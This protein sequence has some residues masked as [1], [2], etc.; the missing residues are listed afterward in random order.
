MAKNKFQSGIEVKGK[1]LLSQESASKALTID[2]NGEITSSATTDTELGHLSGVTSS[3]QTQI[4]A[5]ASQASLDTH[6]GDTN[7]PHSVTKAQVGLSDVPNVDATQRANH[8]GTQLASTISDFTAAAKAA[9]VS[10]T[11][12]D[13]VTDVAPSQ[14]AVFDAVAG[15]GVETIVSSA[16]PFAM[17]LTS[18]RHLN[19]SG[20]VAQTILLPPTPYNGLVV[21]LTNTSTQIITIQDSAAGAVTTVP[22]G[23][24]ATFRYNGTAWGSSMT[25]YR[26]A[27][28]YN[29]ANRAIVNLSEPTNASDAATKNYADSR[30]AD[31]IVD[32]VTNIAPSQNAVY[33]ALLA[34]ID[35][36]Q[37]GVANGVAVLDENTL[38]PLIHIPPAA[39][40]RLVIVADQTARFAL[41]TATVQNGDTVKQ[42]DTNVLY[43]VKD[44]T[45]LNNAAG[46]EVYSA[47]TASS[48]AWSGVTGT[49]TTI[50]GYG[51]TD[52][53]E[54]AQDA[55]GSILTDSASIDFT[56]ND[57]T[58]SI[59]AVVLPAGVDHDQLQNFVANEHV[60]HSTVQIATAS[61]TSG[62]TG[63]GDITATRNIA[64]DITGTT[65][66]TSAENAD[67][68]LIYDV[69]ASALKKITRANLLAG[70][71]GSPGD[72][73]ETSFSLANNQAV[74]ADVTG[75]AFASGVVRSFKVL[76]SVVIDATVD[77]YES[78]EILGIQ[79]GASYDI[80]VNSVG[81]D[82]GIV[83]SIT[84]AGQIQYTSGNAAGFV[85]GTM[86]FRAI[87]TSV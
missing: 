9:A 11:L 55:V 60:D 7:N 32:G 23:H 19:V 1:L 67:E 78:F 59:T 79:K 16:T 40:E 14:N 25:F 39:L 20:T 29:A 74:A 83:F 43:F 38:I 33:D 84:S 75:L 31:G 6:T 82:S 30:V 46:Y 8:T 64:V 26:S 10:D 56:Y 86:K 76:A 45:N 51:I 22:A 48:V 28:G 62:L 42:V 35:A 77:S 69:S 52:A 72:I 13:G 37:K 70:A 5:K 80:A 4:N 87:T 54:V 18:G 73:A 85:S 36:A 68:L 15:Y 50:A 17:T 3:V 49:P 44:D 21:T 47:G 71:T 81:D 65:A 2:A 61:G 57:T 63:G 24:N 34:K 53:D 41:T 27:T 66:V 12:T 58:P